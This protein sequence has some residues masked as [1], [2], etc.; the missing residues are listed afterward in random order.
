MKR[1][2]DFVNDTPRHGK[3]REPHEGGGRPAWHLP[4][5]AA[6]FALAVGFLTLTGPFETYDM[7]LG[8]RLVYW[9]ACI[10]AG[11]LIIPALIFALRRLPPFSAWPAFRRS[12]VAIALAAPLIA[13]CVWWIDGALRPGRDGAPLWL[14]LVNVAAICALIGGILLAR[15][16]PRLDPPGPIPARNAFLD[17]LPP[18]L[19]TDL[20]SLTAQDHYVE[21]VTAK[22]RELIHMRLADAIGDLAD[23]P[24][25]QIHR[26]HWISAH[27]F[28]GT[29]RDD[30]RLMAHLVDGRSLPVSRSFAPQVRRM[31]PVRP[32]PQGPAG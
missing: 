3:P 25:R 4:E 23:F 22:G 18:R 17:R 2:S 21:V 31:Q 32:L 5:Q 14:M 13:A 28:T 19:G 6:G 26:S 27:A 8:P 9:L 10:A 1:R 12:L 30:G 16:R 7:A 15:I 20:I 11:W 29:S 24:G